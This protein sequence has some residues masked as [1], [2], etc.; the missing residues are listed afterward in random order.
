MIYIRNTAE[1][2]SDHSRYECSDDDP[3]EMYRQ[4]YLIFML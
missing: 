3:D 4:V 2:S 1:S